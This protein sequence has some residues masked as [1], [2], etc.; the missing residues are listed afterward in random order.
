MCDNAKVI[1]QQ[2]LKK[3]LKDCQTAKRN[4]MGHVYTKLYLPGGPVTENKTPEE[5]IQH[6][7]QEFSST[8][9]YKFLQ[10]LLLAVLTAESG[11][12]S[13]D[14]YERERITRFAQNF[15]NLDQAVELL[16][17]EEE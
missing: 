1:F 8:E 14:G 11:R 4:D 16:F 7:L 15:C 9:R 2:L 17:G 5:I 12:S 6:Y 3:A 10:D 13:L